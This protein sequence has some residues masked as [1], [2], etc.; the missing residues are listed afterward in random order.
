MPQCGQWAVREPAV[1]LKLGLNATKCSLG[2]KSVIVPLHLRWGCCRV[3]QNSLWDART[4]RVR[5]CHSG[6][7]FLGTRG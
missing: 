2:G 6:L 4:G 7:D 1:G 5:Y 3:W